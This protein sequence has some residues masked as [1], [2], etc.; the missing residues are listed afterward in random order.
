MSDN[1]SKLAELQRNA[2]F[3]DESINKGLFPR[4]QLLLGAR[5]EEYQAAMERDLRAKRRAISSIEPEQKEIAKVVT[6]VQGIKHFLVVA[7][8]QEL[9]AALAW[10]LEKEWAVVKKRIASRTGHVIDFVLGSGEVLKV[11][12]VC[13]THKGMLSTRDLISDIVQLEAPLSVAMVGMMGGIPGKVSLLDV[14]CPMVVYDGTALGT[15][16]GKIL[17]EGR[18]LPMHE[19]IPDILNNMGALFYKGVEI[20]VIKGKH[21]VSVG[22]KID[23]LAPELSQAIIARDAENIIGIEMEAYAVVSAAQTQQLRNE[24]VIFSVFKAVADFCSAVEEL[25]Q[26]TLHRLS[27]LVDLSGIAKPHNPTS[28]KVL[29]QRLQQEATKLSFE[30]ALAFL[31]DLTTVHGY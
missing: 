8:T 23:D 5:L 25:D 4:P 15:K 9:D 1:Q 31:D 29:K 11:G 14:V 10:I 20:R 28:N 21:S 30:V 13:A 27:L 3:L 2:A 16:H 18:P 26:S 7:A 22:E 17:A 19:R 6:A 12:L 24:N